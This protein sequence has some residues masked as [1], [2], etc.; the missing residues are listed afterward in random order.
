MLER[1]NSAIENQDTM[2]I[3]LSVNNT[4]HTHI[5]LTPEDVEE[6]DDSIIIYGTNGQVFEFNTN[7]LFVG[8]EDY[9]VEG[10]YSERA[11]IY[12]A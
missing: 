12:F 3:D 4:F 8:A 1:I 2:M 7:K 11:I 10:D 5:E 9:Y 6:T